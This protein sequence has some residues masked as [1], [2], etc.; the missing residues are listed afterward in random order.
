MAANVTSPPAAAA[1][2]AP[3]RAA[4][5][6]KRRSAAPLRGLLPLVVLLGI[7]ELLGHGSVFFPPTLATSARVASG[8]ST[9]RPACAERIAAA[10]SSAET[11]LSR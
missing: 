3:K 9:G 1:G 8:A 7:W 4:K 2:T 5:T 6:G 10:S 11:C